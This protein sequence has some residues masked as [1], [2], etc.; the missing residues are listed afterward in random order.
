M[1]QCFFLNDIK[2]S[3]QR[4]WALGEEANNVVGKE[5]HFIATH[6]F[7]F[8]PPSIWTNVLK[9]P[10]NSVCRGLVVV[11]LKVF[12]GFRKGIVLFVLL[13]M[14]VGDLYNSLVYPLTLA[15]SK[16]NLWLSGAAFVRPWVLYSWPDNLLYIVAHR[17]KIFFYFMSLPVALRESL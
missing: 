3:G 6:W 14:T 8:C 13:C 9:M 7:T 4:N 17:E 15:F 12:Q 11:L 1:R 16:M 10:C 2:G 5:E